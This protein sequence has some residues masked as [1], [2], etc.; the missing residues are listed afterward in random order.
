MSLVG[1]PHQL[2]TEVWP[3]F[4]QPTYIIK[5]TPPR[6]WTH[7]DSSDQCSPLVSE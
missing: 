1:F 7:M 5:W 4:G 2:A 3:C 6:E